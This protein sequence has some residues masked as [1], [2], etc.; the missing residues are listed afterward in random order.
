MLPKAYLWPFV[1]RIL[2]LSKDLNARDA[3]KEQLLAELHELRK[4]V[5]ELGVL[6]QMS[7]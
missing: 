4:R 7:D 3:V 1:R 6:R 5:A 2:W